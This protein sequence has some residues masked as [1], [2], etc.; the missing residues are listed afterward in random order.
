MT[1]FRYFRM[2]I[3]WI[4]LEISA[5][6]HSDF[7]RRVRVQAADFWRRTQRLALVVVII[8]IVVFVAG[9]FFHSRP[10][11]AIAG[12]L[13]TV[14]WG[15]ILF[16]FASIAELITAVYREIRGREAVGR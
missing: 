6:P 16:F 11:I 10:T 2:V 15:V 3:E 5:L 13:A 7:L 4:S 14:C 8:P 12:L 1:W 9:I